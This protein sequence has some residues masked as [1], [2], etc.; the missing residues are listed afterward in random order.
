M[1][2]PEEGDVWEQ[3]PPS[4]TDAPV[5]VDGEPAVRIRDGQVRILRPLLDSVRVEVVFRV[6]G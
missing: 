4:V 2:R 3:L 6:G 5:L 1:I